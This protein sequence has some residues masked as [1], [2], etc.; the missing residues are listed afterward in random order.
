MERKEQQYEV[1]FSKSPQKN[2]WSDLVKEGKKRD[3][4]TVIGIFRK[5]YSYM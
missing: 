3:Q 5:E 4:L 1:P 2:K